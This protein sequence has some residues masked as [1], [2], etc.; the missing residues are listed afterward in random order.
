MNKT[1][2]ST[3]LL[4]YITH[5]LDF[6]LRCPFQRSLVKLGP[7]WV[8]DKPF[9]SF[10]CTRFPDHHPRTAVRD[11]QNSAAHTEFYLPFLD[12]CLN[13]RAQRTVQRS[14]F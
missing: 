5:P 14:V 6:T 4:R 1:A 3:F 2:N 8:K 10:L 13:Q 11:L 12:E 7:L 9:N